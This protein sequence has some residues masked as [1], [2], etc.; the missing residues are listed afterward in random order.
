MNSTMYIKM[1]KNIL[2]TFLFVFSFSFLSIA[3]VPGYLGKKMSLGYQ[4]NQNTLPFR[5]AYLKSYSNSGIENYL[6]GRTHH[7]KFD[8]A[9]NRHVTLG[10]DFGFS[11]YTLNTRSTIAYNY[12]Y[13]D[14]DLKLNPFTII[15][16]Q[17]GINLTIYAKDFIAPV[18]SY[19]QISLFYHTMSSDDYMGQTSSLAMDQFFNS[20]DIKDRMITETSMFSVRY[21]KG[22]KMALSDRIAI[23]IG[24]YFGIGLNAYSFKLADQGTSDSPFLF[25]QESFAGYAQNC[26]SKNSMFGI[27]LGLAILQ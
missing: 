25:L 9:L 6:F 23:D 8:I 24:F 16:M 7:A 18:G 15:N 2:I 1:T 14:P 12:N 20:P 13:N 17:Y 3:Q 27:S 5:P 10:A 19:H 11:K 4:L 21:T 22:R 26:V